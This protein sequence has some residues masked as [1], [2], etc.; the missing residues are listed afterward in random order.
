MS[1]PSNSGSALANVMNVL[2]RVADPALLQEWRDDEGD[3][4]VKDVVRNHVR[5][6]Q[7]VLSEAHDTDALAA[8]RGVL[9]L[10]QDEAS[11]SVCDWQAMS[12]LAGRYLHLIET[13]V[14]DSQQ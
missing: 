13:G 3:A 9:A 7:A 8:Q 6:A 11:K 2:G 10:I 1:P 14:S 4:A 5:E 12:D